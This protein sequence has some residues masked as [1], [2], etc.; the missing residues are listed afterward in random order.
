MLVALHFLSGGQAT[1]PN[2]QISEASLLE[3]LDFA[4]VEIGE[5]ECP[6]HQRGSNF[7]LN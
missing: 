7:R 3:V 1:L 2:P 6:V 5:V 4:E